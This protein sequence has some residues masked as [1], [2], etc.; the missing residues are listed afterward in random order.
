MLLNRIIEWLTNEYS[1]KIWPV[2]NS[3]VLNLRQISCLTVTDLHQTRSSRGKFTDKLIQN[4]ARGPFQVFFGFFFFLFCAT[5]S[6][7][8]SFKPGIRS[9]QKYIGP[10]RQQPETGLHPVTVLLL[11]SPRSVLL[12]SSF[13]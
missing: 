12:V 1:N 5:D 6:A 13:L 9:N 4:L 3:D 7:Q 8:N 11:F 10:N 2:F